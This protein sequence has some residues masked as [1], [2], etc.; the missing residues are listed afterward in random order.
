MGFHVS[1]GECRDSLRI[2]WG[3]K[4]LIRPSFGV[5][6]KIGGAFYVAGGSGGGV[7]SFHERG[8]SFLGALL[9]KMSVFWGAQGMHVVWS[10]QVNPQ[11]RQSRPRITTMLL[12]SLQELLDSSSY[13]P[14]KLRLLGRRA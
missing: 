14:F 11:A 6:E 5:C 2:D 13:N 12:P 3:T 9:R 8:V 1:L 10:Q 4:G 7:W